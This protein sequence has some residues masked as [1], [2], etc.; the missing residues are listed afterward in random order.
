[1]KVGIHSEGGVASVDGKRER[2]GEEGTGYVCGRSRMDCSLRNYVC[3]R[4]LCVQGKGSVSFGR[5]LG[6]VQAGERA[7][8]VGR[9]RQG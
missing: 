5:G 4:V 8:N 2:E 7:C 3:M 9:G 1:M 6:R